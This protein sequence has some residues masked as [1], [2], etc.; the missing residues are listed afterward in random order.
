MFDGWTK[1]FL[2]DT[3]ECGTNQDVA[4]KLASWSKG[5]LYGM[6]GACIKEG[7]QHLHINGLGD[8]W[9]SDDYEV[10]LAEKW[11]SMVVRRLQ[12]KL[13]TGDIFVDIKRFGEYGLEAYV[14]KAEDLKNPPRGERNMLADK[15]IGKWLTLEMDLVNY[16]ERYYL[17]E[18]RL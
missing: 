18:N 10:Q 15:D 16:T 3:T 12:K 11:P 8:F 6:W 2:D 13:S 9:Q 4:R 1:H 17:S 14:G 5:R 7:K